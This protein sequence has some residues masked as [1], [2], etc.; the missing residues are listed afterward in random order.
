MA[1]A[2]ATVYSPPGVQRTA[3]QTANVHGASKPLRDDRA[4]SQDSDQQSN[5]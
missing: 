5:V 2:G 3:R 4:E 1:I